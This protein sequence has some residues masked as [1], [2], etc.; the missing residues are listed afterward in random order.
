MPQARAAAEPANVVR[1]LEQTDR[2]RFQMAARFDHGVLAAL[3][4]E[5]I[6]RF[7]K[8]D[9]GALLQVPHDFAGKIDMSI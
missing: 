5:M 2:D 9:A 8:S 7:V 3:R 1:D 4:F 6:F